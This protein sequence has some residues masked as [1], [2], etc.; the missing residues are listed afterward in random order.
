[1]IDRFICALKSR[2]EY[3]LVVCCAVAVYLTLRSLGAIEAFDYFVHERNHLSHKEMVPIALTTSVTMMILLLIRDRKLSTEILVRRRAERRAELLARNDLLTGLANRRYFVEDIAARIREQVDTNLIPVVMVLDLDSFKHIN[4][5]HGHAI[6]DL[7]LQRVADQLKIACGDGELVARLGADEFG[8]SAAF[9][10]SDHVY[11]SALAH[12]LRDAVTQ[13]FTIEGLEIDVETS[14]GIATQVGALS[15]G[16]LVKNADQAM[17]RAKR[18]GRNRIAHFDEALGEHLRIRAGLEADLRR[19]IREK[20]FHPHFQP[21]V[22]LADNRIRGFEVLARWHH[23][24]Q[25]V[26]PPSEFIDIAE[27]IGLIGQLGSV[28]LGKACLAARDW[29]PSLTLSFNLSPVQ[30]KDRNLVRS[31]AK[32][33]QETGFP[34][35]RFE[36]EFTEGAL[37]HEF[38]AATKVINALKAEKIKIALDDFGTGYSSLTTLRQLPFDKV[39]I[40]RSLVTNGR[41]DTENAKIVLGIVNLA[42][43][44]GLIA[45]AEGIETQDDEVW[46]RSIGCEQGQGFLYAKAMSCE[47]VSWFLELRGETDVGASMPMTWPGR[48]AG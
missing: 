3:I 35:E 37:I 19:A 36:V 13:R 42:Q 9:E 21:M 29:D 33:L 10:R 26:L 1:M 22:T 20:E 17:Y 39:K 28:V 31:I 46:L 43:T 34:P 47:D 48:E 30:F 6:G 14:I 11:V 25:G 2:Y 38:Q 40:D 15:V 16:D 44:L 24:R 32:T 18:D 4:D 23:P 27:D 45:T 8:V 12:R 41:Q 5:I 7:L